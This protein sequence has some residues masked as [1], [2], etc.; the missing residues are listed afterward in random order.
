[1]GV[2]SWLF[3]FSDGHPQNREVLKPSSSH[4]PPWTLFQTAQLRPGSGT[5]PN[6][7]QANPT[8]PAV[9]RIKLWQVRWCNL[10]L[11]GSQKR[12]AAQFIT[13]TNSSLFQS[14]LSLP[15]K[16][17]LVQ[18]VDVWCVSWYLLNL[19]KLTWQTG[20]KGTPT[21][22]CNLVYIWFFL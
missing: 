7:M 16:R 4:E 8:W 5:P 18:P 10:W 19:E 2:S 11:G 14:L 21:T 22:D 3:P 20:F 15:E 13:L 9:H 6:T 17:G 1:M 12:K